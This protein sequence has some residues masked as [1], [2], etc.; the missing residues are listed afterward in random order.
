MDSP[1][2]NPQRFHSVIYSIQRRETLEIQVTFVL[3]FT[4]IIRLIMFKTFVFYNLF[5]SCKDS[6][7]VGSYNNLLH[8]FVSNYIV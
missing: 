1:S 7:S 8:Y 4:Q 5:N 6:D 3:L 2:Y